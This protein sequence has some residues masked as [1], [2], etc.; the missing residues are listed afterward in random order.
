MAVKWKHVSETQTMVYN[1]KHQPMIYKVE[2]HV[3]FSTKN[4]D[5]QRLSKKL[6][7][8]YVDLY[9]VLSLIERQAY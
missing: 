8:K 9:T 1:H 2:D 4:L 3:W 7:N 6:S 5:Q